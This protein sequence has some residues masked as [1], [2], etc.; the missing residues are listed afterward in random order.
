MAGRQRIRTVAVDEHATVTPIE[1][2]FDLVFVFTLTQVTT[3][4]AG[5]LTVSGMVRGVLV[6]SVL[7]WCWVGWAWL[8]NL[9]RA[10]EGTT[11]I[12][13]FVAM[14]AMFIAA[15]TIP[16]SFTDLPGGLSGPVVFAVCYFIVRLAHF[17]MFWS[18]GYGD[19]GLRRQLVRFIPSLVIGTGLL[20]VASQLTGPVQTI[21][22][23]A[24]L[25]GDYFGTVLA[26]AS[27][28]RVNSASHFAERH[29]LV[30]LIAFGESVVSIGIGV[31]ALPISWPIIVASILGLMIAGSLWWAYFDVVALVAERVLAKAQ[32]EER[33]RLARDSY[34]LLH[35]PMVIGIIF[36]SL[37]LKKVLSYVGGGDG[38]SL[39][40]P[41]YGIPLVAL[42]G[43]A[44]LY[45]LAHV[46]F[47]WR[48]LHSVN[49]QRT[50]VALLLLALIPL[51][52]A[53]PALAT[54]AS[55][56]AILVGL[57]AF[58]TIRYA[59]ARDVV[60]HHGDIATSGPEPT[61]P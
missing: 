60:R 51:V 43:G 40:D 14:A 1:L 57:I 13:M 50:V 8:G 46:A 49:R 24:A 28:W 26:G 48:N 36:L 3:L 33:A 35:L 55:L 41:L 23:L 7:W 17:G 4:M 21:I 20:L 45:L 15:L 9:V 30:I 59:H 56:A 39:T 61:V 34:S 18:A 47:R 11:R 54:L 44:S 42:Y 16:E 37:G 53:L 10:D 12:A 52:A 58:E 38:H 29:G 32:G 25:V 5:D 27:G 6:V 31:T 22:W 19:P 2:F